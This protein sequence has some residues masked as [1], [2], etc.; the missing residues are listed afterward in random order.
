MAGNVAGERQLIGIIKSDDRFQA[1]KSAKWPSSHDPFPSF[2]RD[3]STR[4]SGQP[5]GRAAHR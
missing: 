1:A 2:E 5:A 4:E 3:Q